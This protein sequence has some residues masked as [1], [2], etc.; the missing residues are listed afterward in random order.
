MPGCLQNRFFNVI[1]VV[2]S[3]TDKEA[4]SGNEATR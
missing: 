1:K 3:A 4:F 2:S